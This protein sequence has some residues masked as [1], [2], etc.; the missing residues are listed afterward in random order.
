MDNWLRMENLVILNG[1]NL[2]SR[3]IHAVNKFQ[4]PRELL[5]GLALLDYFRLQVILFFDFLDIV[6]LA[7]D[8]LLIVRID[9][10]S[11]GLLRRLLVVYCNNRLFRSKG[12]Q[13]L[14]V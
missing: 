13:L 6:L 4:E 10:K 9:L 12:L 7:G 14:E 5:G 3:V 8:F 1:R 11:L 2:I